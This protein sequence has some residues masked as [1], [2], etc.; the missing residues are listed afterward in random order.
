MI[1]ALRLTGVKRAIVVHGT[2][3]LDEVR[4]YMRVVSFE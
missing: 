3:G 4:P 1:E 2:N